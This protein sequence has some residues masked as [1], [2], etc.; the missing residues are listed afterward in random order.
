MDDSVNDPDYV[1]ENVGYSDSNDEN[2]NDHGN[3]FLPDSSSDMSD[4]IPLISS[5]PA[6]KRK[7]TSVDYSK[8]Q[9]Q[10]QQHRQS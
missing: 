5:L 8:E 7:H 10:K 2:D 6:L 3:N 1:V 4:T 9:L